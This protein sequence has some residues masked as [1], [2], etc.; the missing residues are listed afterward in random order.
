M[1]QIVCVGRR[2]V[3]CLLLKL[4][5]GPMPCQHEGKSSFVLHNLSCLKQ[6][7]KTKCPVPVPCVNAKTRHKVQAQI[8]CPTVT[9]PV[10]KMPSMSPVVAYFV[11]NTT[12][13]MFICMQNK[14]R[15]RYAWREVNKRNTHSRTSVHNRWHRDMPRGRSKGAH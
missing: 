4:E 13:R 9:M 3:T 7:P 12:K 2:S 5:A 10:H 14:R 11:I 1:S 6:M 8:K 15:E